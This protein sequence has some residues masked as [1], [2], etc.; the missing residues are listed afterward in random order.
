MYSRPLL[1][2]TGLLKVNI[3]TIAIIWFHFTTRCLNNIRLM[4]KKE[5]YKISLCPLPPLLLSYFALVSLN[6]CLYICKCVSFDSFTICWNKNHMTKPSNH[7]TKPSNHMTKPWPQIM[8]T[9]G[10]GGNPDSLPKHCA[11]HTTP[12][13][14]KLNTILYFN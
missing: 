9:G 4:L 10:K 12:Y 7:M 3:S 1:Y 13:C 11:M 2:L 5:D 14:S 6:C 8:P